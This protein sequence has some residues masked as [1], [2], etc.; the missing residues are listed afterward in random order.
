MSSVLIREAVAADLPAINAIYNHYVVNSTCT[1]Q[2]E[3]ET[4]A[5]RAA[6]FAGRGPAHPVIVAEEAGEVLGWGSLSPFHR[7]EAFAGTAENSVYV[8][9]GQHR[10][11]IGSQLLADLLVR[12]REQGLHTI[13]AAISAEQAGSIALHLRHGFRETGRLCEAGR[14][15]G[16]WLDV[17]YLQYFPAGNRVV[18]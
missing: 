15:F 12:G 6:W 1:Y 7:R 4:G 3:P 2:I 10:R 18:G 9:H 14:K 8:H 17:V 16:K 11:G 5:S 13:V